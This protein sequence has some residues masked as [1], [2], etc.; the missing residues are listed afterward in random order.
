[1][2]SARPKS[3]EAEV[4]HNHPPR[5]LRA[6]PRIGR[7]ARPPAAAS[8]ELGKSGYSD[9]VEFEVGLDLLLDGIEKLRQQEGTAAA[10]CW[11]SG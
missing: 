8:V 3:R 4:V 6:T 9:A 1:M 2:N 11:A 10:S 7:R 5:R